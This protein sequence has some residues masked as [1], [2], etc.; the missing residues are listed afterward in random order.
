MLEVNPVRA[1][2]D[3]Y[4]WL[5]HAPDDRTRVVAVDPGDAQVVRQT[6]QNDG[7]T[8]A[9]VLV[10]H[11]HRDHV[12]GV[13]SLVQ[14]FGVPVYGPARESIP[15]PF[16]ALREGDDVELADVGLRF[17][18]MDV[19]GHTAGHIAYVGHGAVF[20]GDTLFSA[21]CG[22]LF[23][24]T[25][26]QMLES[27]TRLSDLPGETLVYCTHEYTLNN[28]RFARV[29]D[30]G[31]L[32]TAAYEESCRQKRSREE[33]TVPSTI[34]RE[35]EINPFLRCASSTVKQAAEAHTGRLLG[36]TTEVFAAVRQ[37]K[38]QF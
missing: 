16:R 33:P 31:N 25:P 26:A 22:R 3:N 7:L 18:V 38:D 4:I 9:A 21:G 12:G 15:G 36:T 14:E 19:P 8:L 5:L 11:H 17:R 27:L 20:C 13:E 24:G 28:L 6:L 32:A 34:A 35:R 29:A 23:E 1:F 10:T 2:A 30:P 37:W